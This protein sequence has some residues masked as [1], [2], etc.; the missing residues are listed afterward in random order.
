MESNSYLNAGEMKLEKHVSTDDR[1]DNVGIS[2]LYELR[3]PRQALFLG[4]AGAV[5]NHIVGDWAVSSLYNYH[6]GAPVN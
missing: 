4:N 5:L 2:A 6:T 3:W 1:P